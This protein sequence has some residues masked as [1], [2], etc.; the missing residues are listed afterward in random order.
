MKQSFQQVDFIR[1]EQSDENRKNL[2]NPKKRTVGGQN[3]DAPLSSEGRKRAPL[4]GL[5]YPLNNDALL[6]PST[7]KRA[8]QTA[9]IGF[10]AHPI[11][12]PDARF[13]EMS[14]G[15]HEGQLVSSLHAPEYFAALKTHGWDYH[16]PEGESLNDV[17]DRVLDGVNDWSEQSDG[18]QLVVVS[19]T[20]AI[21]GLAGRLLG[22]SQEQA[23]RGQN[24]ANGQVSRISRHGSGDW[25][26][27]FV[28]V[29]PAVVAAQDRKNK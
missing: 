28:G 23:I 13:L 10:P 15:I 4:L 3:I 12:T 29:D 25:K 6:V 17:A 16:A 20:T 24:I 22:L 8:I 27:D 2:Q 5:V 19:H 14:Q 18:G 11:Q 26:V 9:E 7:A 1:H 21:R